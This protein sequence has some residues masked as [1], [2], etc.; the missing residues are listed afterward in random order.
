VG[1]SAFETN[2]LMDRKKKL[3][4]G[5]LMFF[6]VDKKSDR[7]QQK[8]TAWQLLNSLDLLISCIF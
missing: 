8:N 3:P 1:R 5:K 7:T 2:H 6:Q 4:V